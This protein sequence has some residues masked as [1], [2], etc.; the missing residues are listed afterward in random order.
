MTAADGIDRRRWPRIAASL[1][2]QMRMA[3]PGDLFRNYHLRDVSLGGMFVKT[4]APRPVGTDVE[5]R[6]DFAQGGTFEARGKVVRVV[7]GRDAADHSDPAG[8][9]IEFTA[10]TDS[11]REL[12]QSILAD[13]KA[14][15][16]EVS[17]EPRSRS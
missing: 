13:G 15:T 3:Q 14:I 10:M 12:L 5:L 6:I 9:G 11:S 1:K 2:I 17:F 7:R 4:D 16:R 8:I